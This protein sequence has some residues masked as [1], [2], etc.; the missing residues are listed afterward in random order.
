MLRYIV[1]SYAFLL[2]LEEPCD[3]PT[4][5]RWIAYKYDQREART[6]QIINYLDD[7]GDRV[8]VTKHA[9]T[10]TVTTSHVF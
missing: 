5:A 1:E 2:P 10:V 7:L 6:A 4:F 8:T 9:R 3:G